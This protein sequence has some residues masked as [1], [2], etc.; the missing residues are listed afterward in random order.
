L[1]EKQAECEGG[2][3][4]SLPMASKRDLG[5][6][7]RQSRHH[8]ITGRASSSVLATHTYTWDNCTS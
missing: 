6:I 4:R 5:E 7:P 8:D 1:H 3:L 2:V